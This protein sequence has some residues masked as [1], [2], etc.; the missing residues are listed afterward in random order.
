MCAW[1]SIVLLGLSA[2]DAPAED[3][4]EPPPEGSA[5]LEGVVLLADRATV[6][7]YEADD[8]GW[9]RL[10]EGDVGDTGCR[11]RK[12]QEVLKLGQGRTLGGVVVAASGFRGRSL[13]ARETH[14]VSFERCELSPNMVSATHGD[15]LKVV[16]RGQ[17]AAPF[18]F[19]AV[20]SPRSLPEG[21]EAV[22][23]LAPGIESLMCPREVGCGR[24]DVVVFHHSLHDVSDIA[25]RFRIEGFPVRQAVGLHAWHPLL[26]ESFIQVW[27]EPGER[28]EVQIVITPPP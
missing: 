12:R 7:A 6:P 25:G 11:P 1:L 27:L 4:R 14:T 24:T 19:G 17:G 13:Y 8:L 23:H 28:K 20:A 9:D 26:P 3:V 16:N 18:T 22:L 5:V 21:G 15:R 2:C 10:F